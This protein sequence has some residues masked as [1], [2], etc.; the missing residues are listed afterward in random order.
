MD[1]PTLKDQCDAYLH[2]FPEKSIQTK[3]FVFWAVN[4]NA[5]PA[6][7]WVKPDMLNC[8]LSGMKPEHSPMIHWLA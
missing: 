2:I 3:Q 7:M 8:D 1:A 4:E 6:L 5:G